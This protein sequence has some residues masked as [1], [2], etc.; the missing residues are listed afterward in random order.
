[1][2]ELRAKAQIIFCACA[3]RFEFVCSKA[4]FRLTRPIFDIAFS[5]Q[6]KAE[7]INRVLGTI[8]L[9]LLYAGSMNI[10][11]YT[12]LVKSCV[13]LMVFYLSGIW[14]TNSHTQREQILNY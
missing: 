14:N 3:G 9:K 4:L 2:Y 13:E 10:S 5:V 6:G 7:F 12:K 8:Y 11:V 1:M